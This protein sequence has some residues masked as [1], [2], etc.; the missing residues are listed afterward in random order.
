MT[1]L[2]KSKLNLTI[3]TLENYIYH[4]YKEMLSA[5]LCIKTVLVFTVTV[6]GLFL[7]PIDITIILI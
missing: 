7:S 1:C 4:L 2:Y 5:N 3:I 6:L